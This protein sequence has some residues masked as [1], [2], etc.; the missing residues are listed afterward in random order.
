[1]FPPIR[2]KIQ[3]ALAKLEQQLVCIFFAVYS[4]APSIQP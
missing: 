2:E 3:D 1:M 4:L